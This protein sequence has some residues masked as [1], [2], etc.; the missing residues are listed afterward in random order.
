M[1]LR[2][3]I[4]IGVS[5]ALLAAGFAVPAEAGIA[6]HRGY[7]M[8]QGSP[9]STPYCQDQYVAQVANEYGF[10]ASPERVRQDPIFKQTLC[11]YIGHDI[12]IKESCDEV[13]PTGRG[14]F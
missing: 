1:A 5:V 4:K 14:R 12:R 11:R 7:Q 6:C 3:N 2:L 9:L 10:K 8:V 13:N